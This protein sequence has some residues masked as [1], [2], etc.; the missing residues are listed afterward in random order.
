V[1]L[2]E[3]F[4]LYH[5]HDSVVHKI[6]HIAEDRLLLMRIDLCEWILPTPYS[7]KRGSFVF[8]GVEELEF[9]QGEPIVEAVIWNDEAISATVLGA[10][11][12]PERNR[13]GLEA[14]KL[15][16][17]FDFFQPKHFE[18]FGTL[19]FLAKNVEWYDLDD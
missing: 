10:D 8:D 7:E 18:E 11:P 5:W 1:K 3:C 13:N 6:E 9:E 4:K 14:A 19:R 17:S 12:V 15:F 16:M 2:S